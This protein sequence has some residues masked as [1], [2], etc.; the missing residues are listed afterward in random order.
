M[1]DPRITAALDSF[2][3][4]NGAARRS[5]F[6]NHR[7]MVLVAVLREVNGLVVSAEIM[8]TGTIHIDSL[9]RILAPL[10]ELGDDQ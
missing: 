5:A 10:A 4:D 3:L 1:T 8:R 6:T 7:V 2:V 9:V